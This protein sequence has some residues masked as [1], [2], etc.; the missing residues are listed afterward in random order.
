M[1]YL[2]RRAVYYSCVISELLHKD[3]ADIFGTIAAAFHAQG[4][5]RIKRILSDETFKKLS[6]TRALDMRINFTTAFCGDKGEFG[7]TEEE[8]TA[9][10]I[11]RDAVALIEELSDDV[12]RSEPL[13]ALLGMEKE[14]NCFSVIAVLIVYIQG[15]YDGISVSTLG[16]ALKKG[17]T[18]AG[19]ILLYF[20][21][22][23]KR[24]MICRELAKNRQIYV[25]PEIA[26]MLATEYGFGR[27]NLMGNLLTEP[28]VKNSEA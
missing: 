17:E 13:D 5:E 16:K 7:S 23:A 9:L 10:E 8:T 21:D 3:C 24:E 20:S 4:A 22:E 12:T 26:D 11:K 14:K 2:E 18:D 27:E 25:Y 6:S 19:I 1:N 15:R 28:T